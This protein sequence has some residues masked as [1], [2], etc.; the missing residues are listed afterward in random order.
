MRGLKVRYGMELGAGEEIWNHYTDVN[1][2]DVRVRRAR[3][4]EV[5]GVECM[6]VRCIEEE[7][8]MERE[9]RLRRE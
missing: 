1:E 4:R 3:L 8:E 9:R 6:C 2:K 5:L 7:E